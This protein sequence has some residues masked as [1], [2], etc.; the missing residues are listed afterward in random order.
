M[1]KLPLD[2]LRVLVTRP[3]CHPTDKWGQAFASA[4]ATVLAYP[5][6]QVVPPPS[7]Q[8]LDQALKELERYDWIVFTSASAV[9]SPGQPSTST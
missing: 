6:I 2:G 8:P 7:W 9:S 3:G 4:G 1:A 5:T